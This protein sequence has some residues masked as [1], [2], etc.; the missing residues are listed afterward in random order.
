[1][2]ISVENVLRSISRPMILRP[3]QIAAGSR[4][5]ANAALSGSR[6]SNSFRATF[7]V[8][9]VGHFQIRTALAVGRGA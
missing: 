4:S 9:S 8:L 6:L 5:Y 7:L 2:R 3:A 1:M